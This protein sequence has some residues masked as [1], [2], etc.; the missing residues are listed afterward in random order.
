M[1]W[2]IATTG[3]IGA[4]S[5]LAAYLMLL[6]HRTSAEGLLY[7][8]LNFLG[9]ACLAVSA[10]AAHAWSS[11]AVNLIWLAIGAAPLGR[12]WVAPQPRATLQ[13]PPRTLASRD[14]ARPAGRPKP[15]LG[16]RSSIRARAPRR[17]CR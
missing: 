14:S 16:P 15:R 13:A 9:S 1:T 17:P 5:V 4:V 3:W 6:R 10:S 8:S 7:L 11:A 12:A 2:L